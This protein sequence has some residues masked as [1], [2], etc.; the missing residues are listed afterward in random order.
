MKVIVLFC[1]L[2]I[3]FFNVS[4]IE[5]EEILPWRE[6]ISL[7]NN[8]A[9][10][11]V[12]THGGSIAAFTI[13]GNAYNPL[14]WSHPEEGNSECIRMGHFVC[15][16]RVG[17]SSSKE[18]ANGMPSHGE[19]GSVIWTVLENHS[20]GDSMTTSLQCNL[21][22]ANLSIHRTLNLWQY[23]PVLEVT[24]TVTNNNVLGRPFNILQHQSCAPPFLSSNVIVD[25]NVE[26]GF[27]QSKSHEKPFEPVLYWPNIEYNGNPVDLRKISES[28]GPGVTNFVIKDGEEYGWTTVINPTVGLLIGYIWKA[29]D[30]PWFRLWRSYN[31]GVPKAMGVEFGTTPFNFTDV[32]LYRIGDV[33]E[34]YVYDYLDTGDSQD[35]SFTMF[36]IEIPGDFTG[37]SEVRRTFEGIEIEERGE[38]GRLIKLTQE[39]IITSAL[40]ETDHTP[41]EKFVVAQNSPNP[42]NPT[43]TISFTLVKAGQVDVNVYNVASQKVDTLVNDLLQAGTHSVVWN[44][45]TFSAGIYFC[46]VKINGLT[47][48]LKMVHIK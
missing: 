30:Y 27:W 32:D 34:R 16:D 22:L 20:P 2:G 48:T 38:S 29:Q 25:A 35:R 13:D 42:F 31:N 37:V 46:T 15:C 11:V 28:N 9:R 1:L 14:N 6:T 3:L 24:D 12:D 36:V 21:P 8:V 5:S 41:A 17:G 26:R 4:A 18:R 7:T 45:S 39:G 47:E 10:V 43:T 19:A 44:A 40:T 23:A 33:F